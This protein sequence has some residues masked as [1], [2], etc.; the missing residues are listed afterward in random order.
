MTHCPTEDV[1][2]EYV[3]GALAGAQLAE[4]EL[5]TKEC[6]RCDALVASQAA[7]WR[8]LNEWKPEPVS[9][10]FNRELWRRI[11]ADAAA[12]SWWAGLRFWKQVAPLAVVLALVVTGFVM[13]R[14]SHPPAATSAAA[15]VSASEADQLERALDDLQLLEAVDSVAPAKP[16]ADV[17]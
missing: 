9:A 13:D 14:Q 4:L 12:P 17:M 5:H 2:L 15:A 3:A 16:A 1:L 11:D 7:V 6:S 10:G 8:S